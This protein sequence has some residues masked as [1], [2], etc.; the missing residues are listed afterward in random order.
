[1]FIVYKSPAPYSELGSS[2]LDRLCR[3]LLPGDPSFRSLNDNTKLSLSFL[4]E[5]LE[6]IERKSMEMGSLLPQ[7]EAVL[8]EFLLFCEFE[9]RIE[10]I[11]LWLQDH[12]LTKIQQFSHIGKNHEA[13]KSQVT[14]F[15]DFTEKCQVSCYVHPS[16]LCIPHQI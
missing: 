2:L 5:K 10:R 8:R 3:P 11:L 7:Q 1:M 15:Q 13:V 16:I 4:R 9:H 12:G 6:E 14:Q